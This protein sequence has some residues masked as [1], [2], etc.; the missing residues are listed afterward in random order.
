MVR[1]LHSTLK[2]TDD[3]SSFE[4]YKA[5]MLC[6]DVY[7]ERKNPIFKQDQSVEHSKV[8]IGS[9]HIA[10][11]IFPGPGTIKSA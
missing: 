2:F 4:N 7:K 8:R 5:T 3:N 11:Q 6:K 1:Y 9:T 10:G